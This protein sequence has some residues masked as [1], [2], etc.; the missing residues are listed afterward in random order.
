MASPLHKK[1]RFMTTA[2]SISWIGLRVDDYLIDEKLG[3][4]AFS[5]VF[6]GSSLNGEAGRAFKVA[7]PI[8]SIDQKHPDAKTQ[9]KIVCSGFVQ[10]VTPDPF[11]LLSR[12]AEKLTKAKQYDNL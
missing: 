11:A 6:R 8:D 9:A 5:Q 2:G 4:G 12:K 10:D 3:E 1:G 7:K